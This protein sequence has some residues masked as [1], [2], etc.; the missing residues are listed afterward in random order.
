[1]RPARGEAAAAAV[2]LRQAAPSP[3]SS[4]ASR[5]RLSPGAC[6]P[7][8]GDLRYLLGGPESPGGD[9][10]RGTGEPCRRG[11]ERRSTRTGGRTMFCFVFFFFFFFPGGIGDGSPG[12]RSRGRE[13]TAAWRR[14]CGMELGLP[15]KGR[16]L[17]GGMLGRLPG[18]PGRAS[19]ASEG[20]GVTRPLANGRA[21]PPAAANPGRPG[22]GPEREVSCPTACP[23][24]RADAPC[25]APG[26]PHGTLGLS[27]PGL[28][29]VQ[30]Q[31][32]SSRPGCGQGITYAQVD[33]TEP[34]EERQEGLKVQEGMPF[35]TGQAKPTQDPG[36]PQPPDL[37]YW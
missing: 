16:G 24:R 17:Q 2:S 8:L 7:P 25:R 20:T 4:S 6:P 37:S 9:G 1:M 19:S 28:T 3:P 5:A 36:E 18:R 27:R 34:P 31:P 22:A 33:L 23:R 11:S 14:G 12:R 10:G 13:R 32:K 26:P 29:L 35:R 15:L 30:V 21:R